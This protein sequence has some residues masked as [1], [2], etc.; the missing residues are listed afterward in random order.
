MALFLCRLPW[1]VKLCGSEA[2][3]NLFDF[4]WPKVEFTFTVQARIK[5]LLRRTTVPY[6][7]TGQLRAAMSSRT[8]VLNCLKNKRSVL[9]PLSK[10]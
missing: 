10:I 9:Q 8:S 1:P 3:Q 4:F 6:L 5:Y 7:R 2:T